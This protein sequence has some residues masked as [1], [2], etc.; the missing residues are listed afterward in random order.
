MNDTIG[1]P[2]SWTAQEIGAVG[3]NIGAVASRAGH[4][5]ADSVPGV[6]HLAVRDLRECLRKG[7]EDFAACRTDVRRR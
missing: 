1:N 2:L 6:R 5:D 3:R 7:A 4:G